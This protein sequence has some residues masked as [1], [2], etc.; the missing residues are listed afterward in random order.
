MKTLKNSSLSGNKLQS[1]EIQQVEDLD[2]PIPLS[3]VDLIP[4]G[5]RTMSFESEKDNLAWEA[6]LASRDINKK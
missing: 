1:R 3:I 2:S 4:Q 6:I 5:E